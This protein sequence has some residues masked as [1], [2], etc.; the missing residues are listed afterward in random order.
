MKTLKCLK[1]RATVIL[2]KSLRADYSNVNQGWLIRPYHKDWSN[3][4]Q[5]AAPVT[6]VVNSKREAI[7]IVLNQVNIIFTNH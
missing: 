2:G 1:T 3:E 4:V 6:R 5:L 7:E